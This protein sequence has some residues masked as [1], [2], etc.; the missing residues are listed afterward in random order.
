[1]DGSSVSIS[2]FSLSPAENSGLR[3]FPEPATYDFK[4]DG[5]TDKCTLEQDIDFKLKSFAISGTVEDGKG[6]GE[7]MILSLTDC[8]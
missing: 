1:M 7:S 4:L 8:E 6:H 3:C 2:Y 5:V